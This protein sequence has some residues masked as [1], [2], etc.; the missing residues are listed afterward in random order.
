MHETPLGEVSFKLRSLSFLWVGG[1]DRLLLLGKNRRITFGFPWTLGDSVF[2]GSAF[3]RTVLPAQAPGPGV[4]L[5]LLTQV[6]EAFAAS[7]SQGINRPAGLLTT[8]SVEQIN[9][10]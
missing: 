7:I 2:G 1:R 5:A 10:L 3:P 4:S 6:A 8:F 9:T